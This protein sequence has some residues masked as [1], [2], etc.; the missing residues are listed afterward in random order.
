MTKKLPAQ[1]F[2]TM[3]SAL[4]KYWAEYGCVIC[5][6]IKNEVGAGTFHPATTIKCLGKKPW[7]AAYIQES[8][9]PSDGRYGN[10]PNR[11]CHYYQFQVLLKPSPDN[12][13]DLFLDSLT[14]IGL[15]STEHDIRFVEDDWQSPTLGAAGL[16]WEVWC[17]GME[18]AQFTYFQQMGGLP[19]AVPSTELTYGLERLAMFCQAVENVYDLDYGGGKKYGELFQANEADYSRY[20]FELSDTKILIDNFNQ[21]EAEATR[22]IDK[23]NIMPAYDEA[24]RASHVFNMLEARGAISVAERQAYIDRVRNLV[25]KILEAVIDAEK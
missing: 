18:V 14:A 23:K 8:Y 22:L 17:D 1:N 13:Q 24:M 12:S 3:V 25:S 4:Q 20:Y 21:A 2:Q 5:F 10:H 19:L 15:D 7:R 9:R 16:G 11:L 6:P